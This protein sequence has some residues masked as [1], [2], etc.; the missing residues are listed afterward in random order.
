[1]CYVVTGGCGFIGSN[2]VNMLTKT[3]D[4]NIIVLDNMTY[5]ADE[6][7]INKCD[8]VRVIKTDIGE[9]SS[10][11][12]DIFAHNNVLGIFHFAAES[13]VDNSITGP[14]I[15]VDT[16]LVGTFNLLD[17]LRQRDWGG[18][19][20]HI[21]T[22]EVYGALS[23]DGPSFLEGKLL[24]PNNVY[25]ATKAGSDL[26]VRAY[27]KT[28]GL[29]VVTTRCCN[30]YGPRQDKEKLL[31]KVIS[32]AINGVKIPIYGRGDNVREW[33]YVEDHCRAIWEIFKLGESGEIYNI[34]SGMEIT[35]LELA[36]KVL[37]SI[38]KP[39]SL[40]K[41]VTD[42]LGHDFR[43]SIDS[44]KFQNLTHN[45]DFTDFDEGLKK[46]IQWYSK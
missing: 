40:I 44:N 17:T 12:D 39:Y 18:R 29:N 21:S 36:K 30:N 6:N 41:H 25:S 26:L 46:T 33:I 4:S 38:D 35:N 43:Y 24:E 5:A 19:F 14:K 37:S 16:N 1:M 3:T 45:F 32:N 2:F 20:V 42:R 13:H 7:N 34:G 31:P 8:R 23:E 15:F 27:N 22:D 11:L 9:Q 28:Y 10:V